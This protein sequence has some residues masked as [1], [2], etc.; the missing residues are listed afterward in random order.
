MKIPKQ[1][2]HS[3]RSE[4]PSLRLGYAR[5]PALALCGIVFLN[6]RTTMLRSTSDV[7]HNE[8]KMWEHVSCETHESVCEMGGCF[9]IFFFSIISST[10]YFEDI[11]REKSFMVRSSQR[12]EGKKLSSKKREGR[13]EVFEVFREIKAEKSW[14]KNRRVVLTSFRRSGKCVRVKEYEN[15]SQ[16][17]I[18]HL[19]KF[20]KSKKKRRKRQK[21]L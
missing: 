17:W 15:V 21:V 10:T 20:K 12:E 2:L 9:L 19:G 16:R 11:G 5:K 3:K 6:S 14:E 4:T 13:I 8:I 18:I 7:T 1:K